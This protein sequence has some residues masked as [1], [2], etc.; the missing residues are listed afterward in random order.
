MRIIVVGGGAAG[1]VAAMYLAALRHRVLVLEKSQRWGGRMRTAHIAPGVRVEAGGARFHRGHT[2]LRH[3]V[4]LCNLNTVDVGALPPVDRGALKAVCG[5]RAGTRSTLP[6][7]HPAVRTLRRQLGYSAEFELSHALEAQRSV[8]GDLTLDNYQI[9]EAGTEALVGCLLRRVRQLGGRAAL[10]AEVRS[11]ARSRSGGWVVRTSRRALRADRVVLAVPASAADRLRPRLGL[12]RHL[13]SCSLMRIYATWP[14]KWWGGLRKQVIGGSPLGIF[15]PVGEKTVM[16][17][18]TDS[19]LAD[20]WNRLRHREARRR[21]WKLLRAAF[22][23][24]DIPRTFAMHRFYWPEG[25]HC[26]RPRE[27]AESDR[28]LAARWIE[29]EPGLHL[30]GEAYS[31]QHQWIEGA[32]ESAAR[33]ALRAHQQGAPGAGGSHRHEPG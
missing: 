7:R 21:L 12:A 3:L 16:A 13:A 10:R 33:V 23:G 15:I 32:V 27:T 4:D 22:P 8:C 31:M 14:R 17:S 29:P 6:P 20:A 18:Y 30:A 28:E 2:A 1:L 11:L 9:L 25:V 19:A 24:R 26:F 5:M